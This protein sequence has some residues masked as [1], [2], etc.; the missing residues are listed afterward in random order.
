MRDPEELLPA[1]WL[2]GAR[3]LLFNYSLQSQFNCQAK[4]VGE[5]RRG[6]D[7][8]GR[9][10]AGESKYLDKSEKSEILPK[11][12]REDWLYFYEKQIP[13]IPST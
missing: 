6:E 5:L 7:S 4:G 13:Q 3:N 10:D 11:R 12:L 9:S 8:G 1:L 2:S